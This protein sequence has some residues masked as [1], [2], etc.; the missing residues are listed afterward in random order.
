MKIGDYVRVM[1]GVHD[2]A[3][4]LHRDGLIVEH[5][6]PQASRIPDQFIVMFPNST[7][8][9]FHKSQLK[10]LKDCPS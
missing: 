3:M 9:K 7:F 5:I 6:I 1:D 8:L 2:E 10:P 4:G